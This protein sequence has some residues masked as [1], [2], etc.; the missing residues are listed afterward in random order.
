[1]SS[2]II[3]C[4]EQIQVEPEVIKQRYE[5]LLSLYNNQFIEGLNN[6]YKGYLFIS[7]E[8]LHCAVNAYY[9]DIYRFKNY[10]GS[11]YADNHKQAAYTIKWIS[12]FRPIQLKENVEP[13]T[14][15]LTINEA[16]AL[17]SGFMFLNPLVIGN[18]SKK[19]YNHLIYTLTYRNIGG[20]GLATIMYLIEQTT[21]GKEL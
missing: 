6:K 10:S 11:K 1:M 5:T 8:L 14:V 15:L 12:R 17:Y 18:I 20:K 21:K 2:E 19:F 7:K 3:D 4:S 16:F 13:D 9:D